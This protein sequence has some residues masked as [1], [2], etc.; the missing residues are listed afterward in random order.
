M[1]VS[2]SALPK[3]GG[4]ENRRD[5]G[6]RSIRG[7]ERPLLTSHRHAKTV[8]YILG[9][10]TDEFDLDLSV[11]DKPT[12]CVE[13]L[14]AL[15]H[16]HWCFDT[17]TVPHERYRVQF[18]L[19]LLMTA[20]TSSRPGAL[21]ESSCVRGSNDA[22]CYGDVALRVL[23]N[24][25]EPERHMLV[26]EVTLRF[27]KGKRNKSQPSVLSKA[28]I[29]AAKLILLRT[30]YIFHERDDNLALCPVSHF[31]ALAFADDAFD[32]SEIRSPEDVYRIPVPSYR[33]SY[34]IKWKSQI[35]DVP[36]FRRTDRHQFGVFIS[37]DRALQYDAFNQLCQRLGRHAGLEDPFTPYCIRRGVA[38]AIDG[39]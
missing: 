39:N 3:R 4:S 5:S 38:N 9:P 35:L 8:K 23:P 32:A 28:R 6:K 22:L 20:Y 21:I 25:E 14:L 34:Q 16:Y 13:D 15:L 36:I 30:T 19:L 29:S 1:E 18:P 2:S 33:N 17:A 12:L 26:M 27:M 10:L 11:K 24:P 37:S 7:K 31:L